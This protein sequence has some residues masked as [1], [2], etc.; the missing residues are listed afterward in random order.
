MLSDVV[1]KAT[2]RT[3]KEEQDNRFFGFLLKRILRTCK[4]QILSWK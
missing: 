1:L 2:S 4:L 3:R